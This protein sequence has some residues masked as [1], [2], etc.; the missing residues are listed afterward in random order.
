MQCGKLLSPDNMH[1][2]CANEAEG[3]MFKLRNFEGSLGPNELGWWAFYDLFGLFMS[4]LI[5]QPRLYSIYFPSIV[6]ITAK[7]FIITQPFCFI[8]MTLETFTRKG[9]K[10]ELSGIAIVLKV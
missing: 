9:G 5:K 1:G 10:P 7:E 8:S 3:K 2:K 6:F 4:K